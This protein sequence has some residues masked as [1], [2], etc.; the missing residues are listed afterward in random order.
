MCKYLTTPR[1]ILKT[2]LWSETTE[3][4]KISLYKTL[5]IFATNFPKKLYQFT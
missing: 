3:P 4:K 2:E 5:Y 1:E